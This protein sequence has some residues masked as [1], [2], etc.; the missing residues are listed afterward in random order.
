MGENVRL[1]MQDINSLVSQKISS[2]YW[3]VYTSSTNEL[4]T[5]FSFRYD[6]SLIISTISYLPTPPPL[7]QDVT[8]GQFLS[9]VYQIWI[10]K[11]S[12][13]QTSC[14]TKAEETSQ[15]YYFFHSCRENNWIHTF[16]KGI[17][18]MWNAISLVQ[19]LNSC[20]RVHF[21]GR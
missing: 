3:N 15:S 13:S 11:F 4:W 10:Q 12:F 1:W 6:V 21:L 9:G 17:S 7:G 18:A 8:Q 19:D 16:P 20:R 2:C 14:L 5:L